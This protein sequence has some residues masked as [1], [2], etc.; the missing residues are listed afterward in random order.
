MSAIVRQQWWVVTRVSKTLPTTT[1]D[2]PIDQHYALPLG[3]VEPV[4]LTIAKFWRWFAFLGH[5][6]PYLSVALA[7]INAFSLVS[8][9]AK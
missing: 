7:A 3:V 4:P 8:I 1:L 9:S 5:S 6:G 2:M